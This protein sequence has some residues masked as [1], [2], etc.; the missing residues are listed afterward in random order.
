MTTTGGKLRDVPSPGS[1]ARATFLELFLDLVY[2]FAFTRLSARLVG[3]F[4]QQRRVIVTETG[5]TV[6]LLLALWLV[7]VLTAQMTSAHDPRRQLVQL[8]VFVVMFGSMIIAVTLPHA[9]G[10]RGV[11]FAV[12]YVAVQAG[13]SLL[14]WYALRGRERLIP[15]RAFF[16]ALISAAP[17]IVG[18]AVVPQSPARGVLWAFAIVFD[19]AGLTFGWPTPGLG[20]AGLS[21]MRLTAEHLAERLQ[22]FVIIT[23]GE[24]I[25]VMGTTFAR[26]FDP[27]GVVPIGLSFITTVLIWRIY[28]YRAGTV[29]A[30]AIRAAPRPV[31]FG[32]SEMHTHLAMITGIFATG[33]GY[34]LVIAHPS[35]HLD[36]AWLGLILG[37]PALFLAGRS[38]F[39]YEV[40]ARVSWSRVLGLVA[41]G[42]LVPAMLPLPPVAAT[43]G[44]TAVLAVVAVRD[45]VRAWRAPEEEPSPPRG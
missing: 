40:F 19:Y 44:A 1:P 22:Q 33:A 2:V 35:G 12:T 29:L 9:F 7:W 41:L 37:G 4:T 17:W 3:D 31:R 32:Q 23:L 36:P 42:A 28:F 13:R 43:A 25:I 16:W 45:A 27:S 15:A 10:A 6:V 39:E 20:R 24:S 11:A 34:A 30:G 5:E 18:G 21:D 26:K 38:R 14:L 8:T